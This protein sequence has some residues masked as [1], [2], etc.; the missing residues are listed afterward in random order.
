MIR[1]IR[2]RARRLTSPPANLAAFIGEIAAGVAAVYG[3]IAARSYAER[4]ERGFCAAIAAPMAC[5]W[6]VGDGGARG[7]GR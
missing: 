3:E 2:N 1:P 6:S 4:A 7:R 5:V